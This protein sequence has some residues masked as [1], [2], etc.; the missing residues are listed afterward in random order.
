MGGFVGFELKEWYV[1]GMSEQKKVI[2]AGAT[3]G[4]LGGGQL[5][6][7]FV[8][9]AQ[10][11]GYRVHV[12]CPEVGGPAAQIADVHTQAGY[13]DLEAVSAF[14]KSVSAV[15]YE[16][17]NV[18]S[19]TAAACAAHAPV[20]PGQR[21][22]RVA[23][24]RVRE[25]N[26]LRDAGIPVTPFVPVE[27]EAQLRAAVEQLG[28]PAVLKTSGGGYDGKGQRVLHSSAEVTYAWEDLGRVPCVLEAMVDFE[29]EVSV[30][31]AR[32]IGGV[33]GEIVTYGPMANSHR[34][35]ILDVSVVPSGATPDVE[36]AAVRIARDIMEK[37]DVVGV[38]CVEF[39]QVRAGTELYE[40]HGPMLV[41]ELAPR[42]HNSGHLTMEAHA[43]S[44][45]E[46]QVRAVS[47][48]PL[49]DAS[50]K[51]PAA[52]VNLLG[53]LWP[54]PGSEICEPDWSG[55]RAAEGLHLHLY[56]KAQARPGRKM[57]HL[58]A[59]ARTPHEAL[60]DAV[61]ARARLSPGT[62]VAPD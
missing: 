25:K 57:G 15:T 34:N 33:G 4:M 56:G 38:L 43:T 19:A 50:L 52:M 60:R 41:N 46:Q 61:E 44:Q 36:A 37:L 47:G 40:T 1:A 59:M 5:G 28:C 39:F 45:F 16:F 10:A 48:L 42:P 31:A 17:E 6:R 58:T 29:Q 3:L 49:G 22:L 7:M 12:F 32:G 24:D 14:A 18:P 54:P 23:Q 35:H 11:L 27:T 8:E 62:R 55:V 26:F 20:R 21:V 2:E 51:K 53:D 9:A 30:V 13:D